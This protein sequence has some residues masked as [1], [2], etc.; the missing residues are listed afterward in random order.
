MSNPSRLALIAL[1]AVGL[2]APAAA[3]EPRPGF[4]IA[5]YAGLL[6][7]DQDFRVANVV[8]FQGLEDSFLFGA[9]LGYTFGRWF[10]LE[11]A[12][13][14]SSQTIG[15]SSLPGS[16]EL[17]VSYLTYGAEAL[18]PLAGGSV[19]PFLAAGLGGLSF[20][21]EADPPAGESSNV[22]TGSFGG[23]LKLPLSPS[24]LARVDA[25][26]V[27]VRQGDREVL[28]L[29][30]GDG[31]LRHNVALSGGLS[32][33][34]GGPGDEDRDGVLDDRDACPGTEPGLPVDRRGCV[35]EVPQGPP[36]IKTDAD[37][38]GV[39]DGLDRCPGTPAGVVVDLD[40]CPVPAAGTPTG[41]DR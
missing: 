35:P 7:F 23:G 3:Q 17:D 39:S 34:F 31:D 18:V 29:F 36:P 21:V 8:G 5:P 28:S 14:Y 2:A 38:D 13:G 19:V 40:G 11:G 1:T 15:P 9:R 33:R 32:L 20:D 10:A 4:E 22:L 12:V 27:L 41:P 16:S 30:D 6:A 37:G 26:D 24:V 25:R